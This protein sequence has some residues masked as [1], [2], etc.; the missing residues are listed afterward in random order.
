MKLAEHGVKLIPK[1][2]A[3]GHTKVKEKQHLAKKIGDKLSELMTRQLEK[4]IQSGLYICFD[5]F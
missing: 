5:L 2:G 4:N 1:P 3:T